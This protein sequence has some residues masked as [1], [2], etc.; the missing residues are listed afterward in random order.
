MSELKRIRVGVIGGGAFGECHLRTLC[1]MPDVE[2]A[3][4]F[5]L[6]RDRGEE[7]CRRYGGRCFHSLNELTD[8]DSIDCATIATPENA[9][10]AAFRALAQRG[11]A[12]YVEKPISTSLIEAQNMLEL[13]SDVLAMSGHCLR[14][15]SRL[16]HVFARQAEL[17]QLRH[18]S[19]RNRRLQGD[20]AIYGRVHPA[21]VLLCHEIELS[22]AFAQDRFKRVCALQTHFTEGQIDGMNILIEY[23]NGVTSSIEGGWYLPTQKSLVEN[24]RC[25]LDFAAGTYETLLP[26][27]G[28]TFL[29]ERGN[30]FLN[31]QY[32]F[33]VYGMEFGALRSALEYW[34]RCIRQKSAPQISTI[35]DAYE[36]VRLV[37]AAIRSAQSGQWVTG[38]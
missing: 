15:E 31:Q 24:D 29:S 23:H 12:I 35:R 38:N 19:F 14:F 1:A 28:F 5:T 27:A 30:Q 33:S 17:G 37:D 13:A 4:L 2:V 34:M 20:K 16:A 18:M 22:N 11:K 25:T 7:L 32:E 36:A 21:Y 10:F 8:D 3:G 26:N 9:H 6:E